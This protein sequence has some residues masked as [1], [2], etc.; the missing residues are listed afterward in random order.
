MGT[1][2]TKMDDT[3]EVG[4]TEEKES[5]TL[6]KEEVRQIANQLTENY[7]KVLEVLTLTSTKFRMYNDGGGVI[8]FKV[9]FNCCYLL[10]VPSDFK[11]IDESNFK[12]IILPALKH[13]SSLT[14]LNIIGMYHVK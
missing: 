2:L 6:T 14:S 10:L 13:N 9:I 7:I 4:S 3:E 12:E 8:C 11:L 1:P 5:E